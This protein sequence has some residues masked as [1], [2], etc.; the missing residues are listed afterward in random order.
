MLSPFGR[1][2]RF[3]DDGSLV[4]PDGQMPIQAV[5]RNVE[6]GSLEPFNL[7][8]FEIPFQYLVPTLTPLKVL[9]SDLLP[10]KFRIPYRL[11]INMKILLQVFDVIL[12]HWS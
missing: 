1:I 4:F 5:L 7:W 10:E 6:F 3:E 9:F 11:T 2:I 12:A 8:F